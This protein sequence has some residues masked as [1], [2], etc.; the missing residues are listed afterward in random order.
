MS[1]VFSLKNKVSVTG[2]ASVFRDKVSITGLPVSKGPHRV[3]VTLSPFLPEDG[4][5][6]SFRNVVFLKKKT[7]DDG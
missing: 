2:S 7:L 5:K 3:G 4:S 1:I 6:A